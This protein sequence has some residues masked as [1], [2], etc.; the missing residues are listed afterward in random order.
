MTI[1]F[2]YAQARAQA[3]LGERLA[4]VSWQLLE[5]NLT[6]AQYLH[7]ARSTDLRNRVRSLTAASSP[8]SIERALRRE[9]RAEVDGTAHWVPARWRPAVEFTSWLCVLPAL[10]HLEQGGEVLPWMGDDVEL[11]P[12]ASDNAE[13]RRREL[14]AAGLGAPGGRDDALA[15]WRQ[16]FEALWPAGDPG[17]RRLGDL[18]DLIDS[19][20]RDPV[21]SARAPAAP[22]QAL[23]AQAV[24]MIRRNVRE[25]VTVFAHL[26]LVALDLG[27]LRGGLVRRALFGDWLAAA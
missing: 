23:E 11:A 24:R 1:E 5:A 19:R 20:R 13:L 25:A 14:L 22:G 26:L 17:V 9:W 27:R 16:H 15:A 21:T 18:A 10:A 2:A 7:A 6:L 8:H 3:R 4:P 12:F